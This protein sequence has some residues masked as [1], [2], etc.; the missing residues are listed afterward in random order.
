MARGIRQRGR[1]SRRVPGPYYWALILLL[2]LVSALIVYFFLRPLPQREVGTP[3]VQRLQVQP[4]PPPEKLKDAVFSFLFEQ[5]VKRHM[6]EVF[7][8]KVEVRLPKAVR[9][10][11]AIALKGHLE[12]AGF[13]VREEDVNGMWLFE[14][15]GVRGERLFVSFP[16]EGLKKHF[17]AIVV[18]DLG[19]KVEDLEM[20]MDVGEPLTFSFL[21]FAAHT[22]GLAQKAKRRG[23]EVLLHLPM[24]PKGYPLENPGKGTLLCSMEEEII[25]AET[26]RALSQL[27]FA[28]GANNHMGS[29][30]T[31]DLE[32]MKVVFR[33]LK[34]K[35]KF[36]LDSLTTPRSMAKE[37]AQIEG[38]KLY[39][40]DVFLDND[41][42]ADNFHR[43]WDLLLRKARQKGEAI[44]ICHPR[45]R[46]MVE[47]RGKVSSL[48]DIELVPL[49]WLSPSL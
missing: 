35:G 26:L 18:D 3:S 41:Q 36:F 48:K 8:D 43:Q 20:L 42:N 1:R 11:L 49:S 25:V 4:C 29:Q 13:R 24:E 44:G 2:P 37:A 31:E 23:F 46:T 38:L 22:K 6:V 40:R 17:L 27:P 12:K 34:Q 15:L 45:E 7:P 9:S 33:V 19:E 47:L 32:K 39:V 16:Q 28:S 30:F 5:G 21:P 14:V 10:S